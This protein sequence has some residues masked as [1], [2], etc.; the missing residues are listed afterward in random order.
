MSKKRDY[1]KVKKDTPLK[2]D[3]RLSA[4][5][6]A[7]QARQKKQ[8]QQMIIAGA[9]A[10]VLIVAITI[11][12]L[13]YYGD[14]VV[15]RV[16]GI[17][18]R[19]SQITPFRQTAEEN[20]LARNADIWTE[21]WDR[22]IREEMVR[23]VA[24]PVIYEDYGRSIGLTFDNDETAATI[25]HMVTQA[26]MDDPALFSDLERF[27]IEGP[28]LA[29]MEAQAE[30]SQFMEDEARA[31]ANDILNRALAGEDFDE[32]MFAYTEDPGIESWPGGYSFVGWQ[33]VPEF[34]EGTLALEIGEVGGPVQSTH[35][36]HIIMR[37]EPD[38]DNMMNPVE[39][40][41]NELLGAKHILIAATRA[42]TQEQIQQQYDSERV[43]FMHHAIASGFHAK[44]N[45]ADLVFRSAL[46]RVDV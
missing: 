16:N 35:G 34:T 17:P 12:L 30:M 40:E 25:T 28:T 10:L 21:D 6:S 31:R 37:I 45:D 38:P 44:L 7:Q 5:K 20:L 22:D 3:E 32:L 15:A 43:Q 29:D 39:H 14:N 11:G 9:A 42:P 27:M 2:K 33:M 18:I 26:I 1:S 36:F 19:G 23:T 13:A 4:K 41:E 24:L 8:R 46:N